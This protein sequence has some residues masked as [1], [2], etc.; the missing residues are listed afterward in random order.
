L[1]VLQVEDDPHV[2]TIVEILLGRSNFEVI[3]TDT[4][5]EALRLAGSIH[6]DI[7]TL[8]VDLPDMNGLEICRQL[9]ADPETALLPVVFF[10]GQSNLA[11]EGLALGAAAF[12]V[13]PNDLTRLG[14]CLREIIDAWRVRRRAA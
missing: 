12:L 5:R 3:S 7:I 8:D 11:E 14:K 6:P 1:K 10:S 13:K 4:G 9:K 2:V